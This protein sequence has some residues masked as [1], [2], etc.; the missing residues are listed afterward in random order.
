L[1]A[2]GMTKGLDY[3]KFAEA[4]DTYAKDVYFLEGDATEE[5]IN[6]L[7]NIPSSITKHHKPYQN[8]YDILQTVKINLKPGDTVLF[9]PGATSF[10]LFQ[11]EFDRGR[12]FNEAVEEVFAPE[13]IKKN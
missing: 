8:F 2:G 6:H 11:N 5:I 9:S 1:I 7:K 12:K 13:V 10:N 3:K 4:I